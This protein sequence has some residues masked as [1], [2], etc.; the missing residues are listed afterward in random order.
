MRLAVLFILLLLVMGCS[1]KSGTPTTSQSPRGAEAPVLTATAAPTPRPTVKPTAT[2]IPRPTATPVPTLKELVA[3][4]LPAVVRV[5]S[6]ETVGTGFF[7]DAEDQ[8]GHILTNEHIVA[9]ESHVDI[10]MSDGTVYDG[11]VLGVDDVQDIAVVRVCCDSFSILR[12]GNDPIEVGTDVVSIGY[13]LGY[14]GEP[15]VTSGIVSALR[16]SSRLGVHV[17]QT[18]AAINPGSSGGPPPVQKR[19]SPRHEHTEG[20]RI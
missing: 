5:S 14:Q 20:R 7:F 15:T 13:A 18:D 9:G 12:F 2:R 10:T 16:W 17:I 4:A 11:E 6:G 3:D 19:R 1:E 8:R